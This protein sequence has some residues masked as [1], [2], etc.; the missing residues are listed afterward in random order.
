METPRARNQSSLRK[1][2]RAAQ[3]ADQRK[4]WTPAEPVVSRRL[5]AQVRL[6]IIRGEEEQR[7]RWGDAKTITGEIVSRE[8][9]GLAGRTH[10]TSMLVRSTTA[11]R[12]GR[13]V[14]LVDSELKVNVGLY[15]PALHHEGKKQD[16]NE[17]A[18]KHRRFQPHPFAFV[19]W[20]HRDG[21][22]S[23]VIGAAQSRNSGPV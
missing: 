22:L 4:R 11:L 19:T 7:R 10:S 8:W 1:F 12:Q 6:T 16:V 20:C 18:P 3:L 21:S 9:D 2:G 5:R 14:A 23:H 17:G 13:A 15:E